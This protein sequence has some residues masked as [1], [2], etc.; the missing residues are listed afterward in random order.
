MRSSPSTAGNLRRQGKLT[1]Q[2][3]VKLHQ[4]LEV[5]IVA[6]GRLAVRRFDVV[7]A[8]IDTCGNRKKGIQVSLWFWYAQAGAFNWSKEIAISSRGFQAHSS[9]P[10][11]MRRFLVPFIANRKELPFPARNGKMPWFAER[12]TIISGFPHPL[13]HEGFGRDLV[14]LF[15]RTHL[16]GDCRLSTESELMGEVVVG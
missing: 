13:A 1:S 7:A 14:V 2:E 8:E 10:K 4:E 16:D 11:G 12:K 15:S 5:D 6:L 9:F 3:A